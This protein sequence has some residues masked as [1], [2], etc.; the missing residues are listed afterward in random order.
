[1]ILQLVNDAAKNIINMYVPSD[2]AMIL[3]HS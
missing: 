2:A 3:E 1:L